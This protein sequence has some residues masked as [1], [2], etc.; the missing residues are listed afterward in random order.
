M[1]SHWNPSLVAGLR[2]VSLRIGKRHWKILLLP[3]SLLRGP[4]YDNCCCPT[5]S[6]A[7]QNF[8]YQAAATTTPTVIYLRDTKA[9]ERPSPQRSS[10][11]TYSHTHT[12]AVGKKNRHCSLGALYCECVCACEL[13][14]LARASKREWLSYRIYWPKICCEFFWKS[15]F[16]K[17]KK[18]AAIILKVI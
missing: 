15:P 11:H 12:H 9:N 8:Y 5:R 10:T 7:E 1:R 17:S 18:N 6:T 16:L 14:G 4:A 2:N 13:G 3:T